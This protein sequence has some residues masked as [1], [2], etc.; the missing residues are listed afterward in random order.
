MLRRAPTVV[1]ALAV[2]LALVAGAAGSDDA[3]P[4]LSAVV[5]LYGSPQT[6]RFRASDDLMAKVDGFCKAH[7]CNG[8]KAFWKIY[9]HVAQLAGRT[10]LEPSRQDTFS[11]IYSNLF[12]GTDTGSGDGSTLA[13]AAA[14][15]ETVAAVVRD[16]GIESLL[17]APCGDLN[18]M[19]RVWREFPALRYTGMDIVPELV[20]NNTRQHGDALR[21]FYHGDLVNDVPAAHD[22]ILCRDTLQHMTVAEAKQTLDNLSRSGSRWLLATTYVVTNVNEDIG[23]TELS[24]KYS[25]SLARQVGSAYNLQLP[26]FNLPSP[27]RTFDE[28]HSGK[29]LGLWELPLTFN[30]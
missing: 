21:T 10:D 18:W 23:A 2:A 20:A 27:V 15:Q 19:P 5:N 28:R 9:R 11:A 22:L 1:L 13:N 16:F 26:P 7:G 25:V 30:Q 3:E 29:C 12:W 8:D 17:D 24:A 4:E 14:T 6:L